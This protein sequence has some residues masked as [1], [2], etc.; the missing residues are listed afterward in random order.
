MLGM[1]Q[2]F[3]GRLSGLASAESVGIFY[4]RHRGAGD[5]LRKWLILRI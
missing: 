3:I 5:E 4:S 2:R 1:L